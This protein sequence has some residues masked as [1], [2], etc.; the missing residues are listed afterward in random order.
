MS[1]SSDCH[2]VITNKIIYQGKVGEK[3]Q[4]LPLKRLFKE[5]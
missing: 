1:D 2:P 5:P 3:S 4:V